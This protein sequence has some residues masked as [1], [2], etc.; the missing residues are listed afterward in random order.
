MASRSERMKT[1]GVRRRRGERG[2]LL[3]VSS[4]VAKD[5]AHEVQAGE[6]RVG[7]PER[8]ARGLSTTDSNGSAGSIPYRR[9]NAFYGNVQ[10][11]GVERIARYGR[12][13]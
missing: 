9:R 6:L 4:A 8:C 13:R 1:V 5:G 12:S 3:C 10:A 7:G 11:D 2:L